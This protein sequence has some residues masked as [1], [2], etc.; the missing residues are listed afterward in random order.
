M[1]VKYGFSMSG[2]MRAMTSEFCLRRVRAVR[3]GV[4]FS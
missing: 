4:N 1:D 2:R 3:F